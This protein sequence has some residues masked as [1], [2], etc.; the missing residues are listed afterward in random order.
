VPDAE[1]TVRPAVEDDA[2]AIAAVHVRS[3]QSAYRGHLPDGYL[4]ALPAQLERREAMWREVIRGHAAGHRVWVADQGGRIVG[5]SGTG[6]SRDDDA[7]AGAIEL[8]TIYLEPDAIGRGVGAA[9]MR[10][11]LADLSERGCR[12]ATLWVLE[13]NERACRFYEKGGWRADGTV[14]EAEL[15][16]ATVREVRYRIAVDA[17]D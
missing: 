16:G 15:W 9:L 8:G 6:P 17:P 14:K 3:W 4:D 11:A 2:A 10:R 1:V 13:G 5:F 12:L 7:P